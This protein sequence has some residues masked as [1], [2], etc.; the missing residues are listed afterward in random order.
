ME[1]RGREKSLEP[2]WGLDRLK[3]GKRSLLGGGNPQGRWHTC[4]SGVPPF[5]GARQHSQACC[6]KEGQ[7]GREMKTYFFSLVIKE[8]GL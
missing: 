6:D 7:G 2:G 8:K 5:R 3:P 4:C 1:N